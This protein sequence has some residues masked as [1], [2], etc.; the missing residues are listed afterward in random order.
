MVAQGEIGNVTSQVEILDAAVTE[1]MVKTKHQ[2]KN[3]RATYLP[4]TRDRWRAH[5]AESPAKWKQIDLYQFVVVT[6]RKNP[7]ENFQ[8][9]T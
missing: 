1:K 9:S 6:R 7:A 3:Q 8:T 4:L 2:T 5:G